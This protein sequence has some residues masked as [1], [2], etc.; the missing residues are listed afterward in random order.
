MGKR[1]NTYKTKSFEGIGRKFTAA[2]GLQYS[3]TSANIYESMMLSKAY[4]SLSNRQK[5][6]Y[7]VCKAQYYG[8]RKPEKDYP[9]L[10]EMKGDDKFYLNFDL[11]QRYGLYTKNMRKEFKADKETLCAKGFIELVSSGA[12]N[13][14]KSVYKYSDKWA[15]EYFQC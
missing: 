8:K 4:Q 6:L 5:V 13:Y 10:E 2:N 7:N 9:E 15:A 3:D 14:K 11:V 1:K 12:T